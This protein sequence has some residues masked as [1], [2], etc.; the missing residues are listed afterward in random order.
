M[1]A[2]EVAR[3]GLNEKECREAGLGVVTA[4]IESTT[5]AGY[6]PGAKPILVKLLAEPGTGRLLGGQ[7]V[8][9]AGSGKRI[10][11]VAVALHAGFTCADLLDTDLSLRAAVRPAL[12]PRRRGRPGAAQAGLIGVFEGRRNIHETTASHGRNDQGTN[13]KSGYDNLSPT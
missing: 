2:T 10:D 7:I 6:L 9:D 1:C 5:R 13:Q 4:T 3:T 11:V 8:G 12:G